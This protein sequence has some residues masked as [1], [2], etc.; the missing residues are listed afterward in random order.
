MNSKLTIIK[1]INVLSDFE[2]TENM[3][4]S[5][6]NKKLLKSDFLR[7]LLNKETSTR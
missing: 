3:A 1:L 2:I 4:I 7:I 6:K 5:S